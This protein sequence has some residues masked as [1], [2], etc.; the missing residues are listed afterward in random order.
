MNLDIPLCFPVGYTQG[1]ERTRTLAC[2]WASVKNPVRAPTAWFGARLNVT[3]LRGW[4]WMVIEFSPEYEYVDGLQ[5]WS[6]MRKVG[7]HRAELPVI[8]DE[9]HTIKGF[10]SHHSFF[11]SACVSLHNLRHPWLTSPCHTS[12]KMQR[13][14]QKL[15]N[16]WT[17]S[18]NTQGWRAALSLKYGIWVQFPSLSKNIRTQPAAALLPTSDLTKTG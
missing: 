2:M 11:L 12:L 18:S 6:V 17:S 8:P 7:L 4:E 15:L 10:F 3:R 16:S 13:T 14:C 9:N 1:C 5:L